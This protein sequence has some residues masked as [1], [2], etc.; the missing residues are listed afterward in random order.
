MR[1]SSFCD[2]ALAFVSRF[3]I[4]EN[5]DM[6]WKVSERYEF[7]CAVPST[8]PLSTSQQEV[9]KGDLLVIYLAFSFF[10]RALSRRSRLTKSLMKLAIPIQ[11]SLL[12]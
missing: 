8:N 12:I 7:Y 9:S 5:H 10:A 6:S 3:V 11:I 4:S 1:L 2:D